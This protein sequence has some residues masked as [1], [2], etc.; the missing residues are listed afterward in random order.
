MTT[1]TEAMKLAL[2]ELLKHAKRANE[3][4]LHEAG[5]GVC[6]VTAIARAE[7]ALAQAPAQQGT[8]ALRELV[9]L[10]DIKERY[11]RLCDAAEPGTAEEALAL[12]ADYNNRKPLAWAAARAALAQAEQS[13]GK[14]GAVIINGATVCCEE[15]DREPCPHQPEQRCKSCPGNAQAEQPDNIPATAAQEA[16]TDEALGL[17]LLPPIRV[18]AR[19]HAILQRIAEVRGIVLQAL[20]REALEAGPTMGQAEQP[21]EPDTVPWPVVTAYSGGASHDGIGG[22]VWVRLEDGGQQVEYAP[23]KQAEQ[24]QP[25]AALLR[26]RHVTTWPHAAVDGKTHYSEWG[27]WLPTTYKHAK[28][29]TD[30]SRNTDPVCYEMQ[31]L[32]AAPPAAPQP[33]ALDLTGEAINEAAWAF[34]ETCPVSLPGPIFNNL[35]ACLVASIKVWL[36]AAPTQAATLTMRPMGPSE[37]DPERKGWYIDG[38]EFYCDVERA[39]SG[40]WS[41]YF[42]DRATGKDAFGKKA[43]PLVALT[44]AAQARDDAIWYDIRA[45]LRAVIEDGH[46]ADLDE[47]DAKRLLDLIDAAPPPAAPLTDADIEAVMG[48]CQGSEF[49]EH[50]RRE[51]IKSFKRVYF[52]L[53]PERANGIHAQ[54]GATQAQ[55]VKPAQEGGAS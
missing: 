1:P 36:A 44:Q 25:V 11:E 54:E 28:A 29:V 48:P 52:K 13:K 9:A 6:D 20:V 39:A 45:T 16:A 46:S 49:A 53:H 14:P 38:P 32:Y 18:S 22:R 31:P 43:A 17:V 55:E 33:V 12:E 3:I 51:F 10:K 5:I 30:P 41:V 4:M 23:V 24:A 35:K 8:E 26:S 34:V 47:V 19:S 21:A 40:E 42:K 7:A 15:F 27:D 2:A 37:E 50:L